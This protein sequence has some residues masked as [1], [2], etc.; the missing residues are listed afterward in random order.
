ME[1]S[2]SDPEAID[3]EKSADELPEGQRNAD[4]DGAKPRA[5]GQA[6]AAIVKKLLTERTPRLTFIRGSPASKSW[7]P[8][9]KKGDSLQYIADMHE[10]QVLNITV[11]GYHS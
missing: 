11:Y 9:T 8:E 4:V 3:F 10:I 1:E 7:R 5:L 2:L 6:R